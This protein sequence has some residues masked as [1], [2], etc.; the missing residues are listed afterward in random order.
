MTTFSVRFARAFLRSVAPTPR[1]RLDMHASEFIYRE[2]KGLDLR[3]R[4]T[5]SRRV[6]YVI[7][8]VVLGAS[9][10]CDEGPSNPGLAP[11]DAQS[12]V[13]ATTTDFQTGS[14]SVVW[15]D[16][17]YIP[18]SDVELIHSDAVARYFEGLIYV[19]NRFNGDNI[20][21]LDPAS[22]FATIRQFSVG[23]G[24]DPHD[25]AIV[26]TTKAYVSRYNSTELW[27]V[28]PSNGQKIGS[29]ELSAFADAD[30]LP[31]MHAM[32]VRDDRLFVTLQRLDRL[33]DWGPVGTSYAAVIDATADTLLD[34]DSQT[35]GS[36]PLT[37]MGTNP[38]SDI[39]FDE[40]TGTVCVA[41]VGEWGLT[42]G[43]VESI[44]PVSLVSN[45]FILSEAIVQGD[46]SDVVLASAQTGFVIITDSN[47]SNLL[48]S[49]DPSSGALTDTLY[50]PGAFVLQDAELS[51]A[52]TLFVTDRSPTQPGIRVFDIGTRKEVTTTPLNVGL[53]PFDLTFGQVRR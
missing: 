52:G 8:F 40:A 5:L 31:E 17:E 38:F 33:T 35:A 2:H 16:E 4:L 3:R 41:S 25:I 19:V 24:S 6:F 22:D 20:Q 28:N 37:L 47:F 18:E 12:F 23:N 13:F 43:G 9:G 15:L 32:I 27:V 44:D 42:D 7:C 30:G 50:A 1:K 46:I 53:P 49:F 51:P 14:A 39:L 26:S 21:V 11:I 10:A 29:I 48:L 45:G 36:Q 34:A